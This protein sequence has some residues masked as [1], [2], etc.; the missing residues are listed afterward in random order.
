MYTVNGT[1]FDSFLA[2]VKAA[3]EVGGNVILSTTG[4][5]KWS[6]APAVSRKRLRRY[7]EQLNACKAQTNLRPEA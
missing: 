5:V 7:R 3:S 1:P 6:P 2:A 4:A